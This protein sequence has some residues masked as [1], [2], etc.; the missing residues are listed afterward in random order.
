MNP[1]ECPYCHKAALLPWRRLMLG[2]A[3]SVACQNCGGKVGL[4]WTSIWTI[5]PFIVAVIIA[6]FVSTPL[7]VVIWIAG[8][9]LSFWL[10]YKFAPLVTK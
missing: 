5:V 2:P 7:S 10:N 8:I 1:L 3:W 9:A 4:A 6:S